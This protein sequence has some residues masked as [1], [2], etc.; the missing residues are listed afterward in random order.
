MLLA[1][2]AFALTPMLGGTG[3]GQLP[4]FREVPLDEHRIVALLSA[5]K[6]SATCREVLGRHLPA[7]A[8][9]SGVAETF[10]RCPAR[11]PKGVVCERFIAVHHD[12]VAGGV[13]I[14]PKGELPV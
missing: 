1:L 14:H 12:W 11:L 9:F 4:S 8:H 6:P 2:A 5:C 13:R 3:A 10:P 7:P